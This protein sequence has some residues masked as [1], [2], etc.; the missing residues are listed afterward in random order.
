[1]ST[2]PRPL[3]HTAAEQGWRDIELGDIQATYKEVPPNKNRRG[4]NHNT[5]TPATSVTKQARRKRSCVRRV[6]CFVAWFVLVLAL[7]VTVFM[8]SYYLLRQT[9]ELSK[10][11]YASNEEENAKS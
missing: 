5:Y 8:I 7:G 9:A 3:A 11:D 6:A 4:D 10:G 1:M 2:F